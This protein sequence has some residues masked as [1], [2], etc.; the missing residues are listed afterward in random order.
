MGVY[1]TADEIKNTLEGKTFK[2]ITSLK[3]L[4]DSMEV[5]I[6]KE[7]WGGNEWSDEFRKGVE[8]DIDSISK[9][10][11]KLGKIKRKY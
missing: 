1:T 9:I 7:T 3:E 10:I 5:V 4:R 11:S 2:I 6:N 8:D